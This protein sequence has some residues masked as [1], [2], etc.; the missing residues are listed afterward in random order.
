[1]EFRVWKHTITRI[2]VQW[3]ASAEERKEQ[4]KS[5][6]WKMEQYKSFNVNIEKI[7]GLILSLPHSLLLSW[8]SEDQGGVALLL[9]ARKEKPTSNTSV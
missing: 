5:E 1:M 6:N 7:D 2:K 3:M 9:L 8:K 4:G